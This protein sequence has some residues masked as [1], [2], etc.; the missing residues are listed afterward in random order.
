MYR[1]WKWFCCIAIWLTMESLWLETCL[2]KLL[3]KWLDKWLFMWL[4]ACISSKSD[5]LTLHYAISKANS[6]R[7][8]VFL[9]LIKLI[10]FLHPL[11][12]IIIPIVWVGGYYRNNGK[13]DEEEDSPFSPCY[14]FF[15]DWR[16]SHSVV[17]GENVQTAWER[18]KHWKNVKACCV[19][20]DLCEFAFL[21]W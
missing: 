12:K 17:V 4:I 20:V 6:V 5:A 3:E 13:G 1:I 9:L 19:F 2:E 10:D 8:L 18:G 11:V 21:L 16:F 15:V 7:I 14:P